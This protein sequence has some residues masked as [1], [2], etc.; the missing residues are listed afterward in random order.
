MA[1]E[2]VFVVGA[3]AS[4]PYGMPSGAELR[5]AIEGRDWLFDSNEQPP[6]R[7]RNGF[8]CLGE[9]VNPAHVHSFFRAFS[10]APQESIDRFL[11]ANPELAQ[12]GKWCIADCLLEKEQT[13][14]IDKRRTS[15][16]WLQSVFNQMNLSLHP[17]RL[18]KIAFVTFNYDRLIERY[19]EQAF[20][21]ACI[22]Q[23]GLNQR[24][25][26]VHV[27]GSL[28]NYPGDRFPQLND[29]PGGHGTTQISFEEIDNAANNIQIIH[30]TEG[31]EEAK[32]LLKE[33]RKIVFL[34]FS[35]AEENMR[36]IWPWEEGANSGG[37]IFGTSHGLLDGEVE[38]IPLLVN[39]A[40]LRVRSSGRSGPMGGVG[41]DC[42][43]IL[44]KY[45]VLPR[46]D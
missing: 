12:I 45:D 32:N 17:E 22:G 5:E 24:L 15:G 46:F 44:R 10:R 7:R 9:Q 1:H 21:F 27:H 3:G 6:G 26:V 34:G 42:E 41:E 38:R 13:C 20:Q 18:E 35:Y 16:H 4:M 19:F 40:R 30:E 23:P 2:T 39:S 33:A 8:N 31:H 43:T 37:Q 36:K 14:S 25:K 28:G 29:A 11:A